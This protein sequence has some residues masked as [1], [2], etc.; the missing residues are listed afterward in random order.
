ME[1]I[2]VTSLSGGCGKT[3]A[4]ALIASSFSGKKVLLCSLDEYSAS[5]RL[6][7]SME[8]DFLLDI[9][10]YR[11]NLLSDIARPVKGFENLYL[12]VRLPFSGK[13][14]SEVDLVNY[15]KFSREFDIAII[16]KGEGSAEEKTLL[17]KEVDRVIV[18]SEETNASLHSAEIL[19]IILHENKISGPELL[20]NSFYTDQRARKY[21]PGIAAASAKVGL[22]IIGILPYSDALTAFPDISA[23]KEDKSLS[24][25][26]RSIAERIC[27]RD[28]KLLSFLSEKE[29]RRLL[30]S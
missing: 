7:F 19:S 16:D 6:F 22:P 15:L 23:K 26:A 11:E 20:I 8:S 17:A 4:S 24:A 27:G 10:D 21:F 28:E 29:R 14:L 5:M 30:N 12:A 3:T 13:K 18:V 1:T 25:A 2:L 9:S